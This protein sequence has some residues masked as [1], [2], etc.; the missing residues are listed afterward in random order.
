VVGAS[1]IAR[2]ITDRRQAEAERAQLLERER[3]AHAEIERAG[4]LKDDFLAVLSHE[5]RTPLNA[6]LG[7]TQLLI[8]GALSKDDVAHAYLAIQRNAQAQGRL[9]ESLLDLSRILAG[10]LEL[11]PEAV[12]LASVVAQAVD[13]VRPEALAK[14]IALDVS[15]SPGIRVFADAARLQQVFWNLLANAIKFTPSGGRVTVQLAAGDADVSVRVEDNGRGIPDSLL[16]FVFDRFRQ[17][18]GESGRSRAGLGLGLALVREM[19][20]A[21]KGTVT[22]ESPGEG[23][24]STFIVRLPLFLSRQIGASEIG[25]PMREQE[26]DLSGLRFDVLVVDDERDARDMLTL[27]LETRGAKV[28]SAG[29]ATE[30]FE[31]MSKRSPDLLLADLGVA[32]EDGLSLIRRWRLKEDA[33]KRPGIAAIAVTAD[34]SPTDR[35]RALLAGYNWHL[36]KPIDATELVRV[37]AQVITTTKSMAGS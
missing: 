2:D 9:V 23:R 33:E 29:S 12:D 19:V 17:G 36:A 31:L 21:H 11:N 13:A 37:I 8:S 24:G 28:R 18:E 35:E 32:A 27:M 30:A 3:Q 26:S 5:L 1:K 10:K 16:P 14:R 7:Y 22:A 6:V 20:H 15:D 4:R 25:H 34:A